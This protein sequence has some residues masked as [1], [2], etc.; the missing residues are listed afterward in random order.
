[1]ILTQT[2]QVQWKSWTYLSGWWCWAT[3]LKNMS[4]SMGRMTS[5]ILWKIKNGPKP[6]TRY[7]F[8]L[9]EGL[10]FREYPNKRWPYMVLTYLHFRI[11]NFP[12]I[13][14]WHHRFTTWMISSLPFHVIWNFQK[15]PCPVD[16]VSGTRNNSLDVISHSVSV[17]Y[18]SLYICV[19]HITI[20]IYNYNIL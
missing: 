19:I 4:S 6:P 12:L 1:M 16:S 15:K 11:R 5:H 2:F 3:P 20:Y 9:V 10:N 18:T 17:V 14:Y 13:L 7:I 8:G